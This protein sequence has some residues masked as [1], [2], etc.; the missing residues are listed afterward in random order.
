MDIFTYSDPGGR[1]ENEDTVQYAQSGNCV[2]MVLAD[3]LGG[4]G[5][6][7]AASVTVCESL[8][9]C[10]E[11][12][13]FPGRQT[14]EEAFRTANE[15]LI[16]R[17]KNDFHMKTTAVYFF[18]DGTRAIWAH[19]GDSRL[20]HVFHHNIEDVTLDHSASQLSV[21]M[22]DITRD[23]IPKDPAR[24]R[25][26][27][28]MGVK[29]S[30]PDVHEAVVLEPGRHA[31]L[32]CSD[33]LWEYL[34][35]SDIVSCCEN[36]FSDE[37]LKSGCIPGST[38]TGCIPEDKLTGSAERCLKMLYEIKQSRSIPECDNNTAS[39]IFMEV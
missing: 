30:M 20:Y 3:G 19:I 7:K 6:G 17:Q 18:T 11:N 28:A 27:R 21:F 25:L 8:I 37:T 9:H 22:G 15:T 4:Q 39:L 34:T 36:V 10:G 35:D 23:Q 33:G 16:S 5:D 31:F 38:S 24:N 12:G 13:G 1:R 29:G 2:I 32:L 26:I 14:I